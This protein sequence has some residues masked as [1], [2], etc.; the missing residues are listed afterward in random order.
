MVCRGLSWLIVVLFVYI[1]KF[2]FL[3]Q[4]NDNHPKIKALLLG[5]FKKTKKEQKNY[6]CICSIRKR[7]K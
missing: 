3:N 1:P 4:V 6:D 7:K 2:G 5:S